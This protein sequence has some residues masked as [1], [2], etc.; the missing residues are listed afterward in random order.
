MKALLEELKS[1]NPHIE[2]S[3][4]VASLDSVGIGLLNNYRDH[5]LINMAELGTS[6]DTMYEL[7]SFE[8][9]KVT[10]L[11]GEERKEFKL[12]MSVNGI[13]GSIRINIESNSFLLV[14]STLRN[15]LSP[16]GLETC[17]QL[18]ARRIDGLLA[19]KYPKIC[20]QAMHL[21]FDFNQDIPT[22][23][24]SR[25]ELKVKQYLY[26]QLRR[27]ESRKSAIEDD[28]SVIDFE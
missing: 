22:S 28:I 7:E 20:R 6:P 19:R 11:V 2:I 23:E 13:V 1:L 15:C 18:K 16:F 5:F 10:I 4:S 14:N 25:S 3:S 8:L 26:Q 24:L 21:G 12:K 9:P 27:R 17:R